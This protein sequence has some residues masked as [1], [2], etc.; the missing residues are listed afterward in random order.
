MTRR[1]IM[2]AGLDP[3]DVTWINDNVAITNF[4][5]AHDKELL[6]NHRVGAVLCLDRELEGCPSHERGIAC[7]RVV[8]LVDG[9]NEMSRFREAVD[10]LAFLVKRH[11]RVVVH[12]R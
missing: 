12:C 4:P 9:A 3:T 2:V 5:S 6:A 1:M 11:G 10:A 8:H 7:V